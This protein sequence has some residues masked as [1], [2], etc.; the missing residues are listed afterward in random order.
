GY[1]AL[2]L[3]RELRPDIALVDIAM[4]ALNGLEVALR[5]RKASPRTR[6]VMLTMHDDAEY[7]RQALA[8]G[9]AGFLLKQTSVGELEAALRAVS[10]GGS[11]LSPAIAATVASAAA[12]SNDLD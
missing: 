1:E 2:Q 11:W 12:E 5:A 7:V 4:P 6:V 8:C 10:E 9:A 3:I